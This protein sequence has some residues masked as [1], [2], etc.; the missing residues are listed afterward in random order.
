MTGLGAVAALAA[1]P[2]VAELVDD[3][4]VANVAPAACH[5]VVVVDRADRGGD[6]RAAVVGD[7]VVHDRLLHGVVA[8]H[9]LHEPLIG[10]PI[11]AREDPRGADRR[12]ARDGWIGERARDVLRGAGDVVEKARDRAGVEIGDVHEGDADAGNVRRVARRQ[13]D[14]VLRVARVRHGELRRRVPLV[15][16]GVGHVLVGGKE[17]PVA[18]ARRVV[19]GAQLDV[20]AVL[21]ADFGDPVH[22][23]A[24]VELARVDDVGGVEERLAAGRSRVG[25]EDR[26]SAL[27]RQRSMHRGRGEG[28]LGRDDVAGRAR[29][30]DGRRTGPGEEREEE[31]TDEEGEAAR[32]AHSE[33][34]D[35]PLPFLVTPP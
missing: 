4:V 11:G 18:P 1:G 6:V 32:V 27:G 9:P 26:A 33:H 10:R 25:R 28:P 34:G 31:E 5:R 22:A 35:V 16:V 14:A 17:R 15:R 29:R 7:G 3:V 8:R 13:P 24:V 21:G 30:R 20:E 12:R 23:D 2:H 19:R